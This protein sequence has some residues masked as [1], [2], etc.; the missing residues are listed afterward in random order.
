MNTRAQFQGVQVET[1]CELL[2]RDAIRVLDARDR[3]SFEQARIAPA[4]H[5]SSTNLDELIFG[6]P[7]HAP[8]LI[9]CYHGHA[10]KTY[11]QTFVD[12]GFQEVYSLEGGFDAWCKAQAASTAPGLSATLKHWLTQHDYPTHGIDTTAAHGITPLMRASLEGNAVIVAELIQAGAR[13]D[14]K[15]IDGNNALWLACVG[16]NL[17]V[18]DLLVAA[19]IDID[20]QN[21]NG[22][23]CL[24][25]AASSGKAAVLKK[26]LT[27][28]ANTQIKTLDDFTALGMAATLD[29]L[30]LLRNSG[31]VE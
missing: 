5:L 13:I 11:A 24:M 8:V 12:F 31:A 9:Y 6:T 17:E 1:V 3:A 7:K 28:G 25:Y 2:K 14:T 19:G 27:A 30:T 29:C 20:H 26:L 10:S 15:N 23:T 4:V 21:D 22:A 16:E 18:F